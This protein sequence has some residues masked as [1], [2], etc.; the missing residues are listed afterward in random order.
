MKNADT[1][2]R[3]DEA[4]LVRGNTPRNWPFGTDVVCSECKLAYERGAFK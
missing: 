1:A 2:M 4:E 3:R